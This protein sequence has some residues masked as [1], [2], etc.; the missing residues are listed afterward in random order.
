VVDPVTVIV[1]PWALDA[2]Q[3]FTFP[4]NWTQ[5]GPR[6]LKFEMPPPPHVVVNTVAPAAHP[7]PVH[8]PLSHVEPVAQ[9]VPQPPQLLLSVCSLTHEPLQAE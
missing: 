5:T 2:F 1:R 4:L 6:E 8:V 7:P 9:T 3:P